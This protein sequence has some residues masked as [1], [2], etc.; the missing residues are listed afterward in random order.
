M[1]ILFVG[2]NPDQASN[3]NL[4]KEI[5]EVQRRTL[6]NTTDPARFVVL[7]Q[8]SFEE[9]PITLFREK[10]D[11]L[12]VSAHGSDGRLMFANEAGRQIC[13]DADTLNTF[14]S[15]EFPP[16]IVY[17]NAC[18]SEAIGLSLLKKVPMVIGSTAPITNRSAISAAVVFY[19]HVLAGASVAR[20]FEVCQKMI[21][22]SM[23]DAASMVLH[24]RENIEPEREILY[25]IPRIIAE[26]QILS[27]GRKK[28]KSL[29]V[30]FGLFGCPPST[31]QVV[32]FT[33]DQSF[34]TGKN[35]YENDLCHV[36]RTPPKQ[37]VLW[38]RGY[39]WITNGD[40]RIFAAATLPDGK[41]LFASAMLSA[42]LRYRYEVISLNKEKTDNMLSEVFEILRGDNESP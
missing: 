19:E 8:L 12:H 30:R 40:F 26:Y 38:A 41:N 2:S 25:Q 9:F 27:Q 29:R 42:A 23:A 14:I 4:L 7:P 15:D 1:K 18:N 39:G 20:A 32:F 16:K 34:I 3:L 35:S 33:D 37:G 31:S 6:S 11:I 10:P 24:K 17:M 13:L 5:N 28:K 22:V 36:V 21:E